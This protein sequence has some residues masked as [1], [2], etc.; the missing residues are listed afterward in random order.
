[1]NK[2]TEFRMPLT[3][4]TLETFKNQNWVKVDVEEGFGDDDSEFKM[5]PDFY[6]KLNIPKERNDDYAPS[7]VSSLS[8]D[9]RA[10]TDMG[11][12]PNE[13]MIQLHDM[14]GLGMCKYEEELEALY[15]LLTGYDIYE[16]PPPEE[17]ISEFM[18][19]L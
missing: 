2:I 10:L 11:F 17:Q 7:F 5:V 1:M 15:K 4:I 6:Y 9:R 18:V 14:D 12:K 16:T 3:P 19:R 13:F 8:S